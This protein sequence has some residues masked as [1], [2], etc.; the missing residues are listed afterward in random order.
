MEET[1]YKMENNN[2]EQLKSMELGGDSFKVGMSLGVLSGAVACGDHDDM[3]AILAQAVGHLKESVEDQRTVLSKL[4]LNAAKQFVRNLEDSL[5]NGDDRS[6]SIAATALVEGS[7]NARED[8]DT[9]LGSDVSCPD[10]GCG[11]CQGC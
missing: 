9:M 5:E 7:C 3:A 8:I 4:L 11:G 1:E 10:S 6:F 2:E